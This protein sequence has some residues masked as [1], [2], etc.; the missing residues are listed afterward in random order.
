MLLLTTVVL[1]HWFRSSSDADDEVASF[2][3]SSPCYPRQGDFLLSGCRLHFPCRFHLGKVLAPACHARHFGN[4]AA[5]FKGSGAL[6]NG[7]AAARC[8]CSRLTNAVAY[9]GRRITSI[10]GNRRNRRRPAR[11]FPK[12][13]PSPRRSPRAIVSLRCPSQPTV[14]VQRTRSSGFEI[15]PLW[16]RRIPRDARGYPRGCRCP[17]RP[18]ATFCDAAAMPKSEHR[19]VGSALVGRKRPANRCACRRA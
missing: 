18:C 2:P 7:E 10:D 9:L 11:S 8:Q 15:R 14:R 19:P 13:V 6:A 12:S 1:P 16:K 3:P 17:R 5:P 4:A